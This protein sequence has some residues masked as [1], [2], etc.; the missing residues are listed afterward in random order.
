MTIKDKKQ[1]C[2]DILN[3]YDIGHIIKD[4]LSFLIS[5][6]K[7]HPEWEVKRGVGGKNIFIGK[8]N[9]GHRCFYITRK[10]NTI[11]DISYIKSISGK[12]DS[13]LIKINKACR[14]AI[15]SEIVNFRNKNVIYGATRC[16]VT[17]DILTKENTHIDHYDFTFDYMFKNWIANK[18]VKELVKCLNKDKD[19]TQGYYFIDRLIK[20]DFINFHNTNCKLRAVTKYANLSILK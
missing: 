1:K 7:N 10:D 9:Y 13:D 6:F 3:K 12:K 8:D 19:L 18:D 4:E 11:T 17:N 15:R 2:K 5:L 14:T 20:N 16:S